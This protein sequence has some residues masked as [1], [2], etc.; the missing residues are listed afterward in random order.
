MRLPELLKVSL[1]QATQLSPACTYP[2]LHAQMLDP[3]IEYALFGQD[4]QS[5]WPGSGLYEFAVQ[6]AQLLLM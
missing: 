3:A 4:L 2:A 6:F 1:E 5:V